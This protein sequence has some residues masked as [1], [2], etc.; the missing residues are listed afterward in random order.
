VRGRRREAQ[1][2]LEA[3]QSK[4]EQGPPTTRDMRSVREQFHTSA[5]RR[6]SAAE[7]WLLFAAIPS[8]LLWAVVVL[9]ISGDI[10]GALQ[11]ACTATAAG[12]VGWCLGDTLR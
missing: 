12:F 5:R 3:R 7:K 8:L 11:V 6:R 2:G 4:Q 10:R 9:A 1:I